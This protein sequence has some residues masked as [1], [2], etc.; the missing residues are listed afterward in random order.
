MSK[1]CPASK[2]LESLM[3]TGIEAF[4]LLSSRFNIVL[5]R[6]NIYTCLQFYY[7]FIYFLVILYT[8]V[9]FF[10]V[11][12]DTTEFC[13]TFGQILIL[14]IFPRIFRGHFV[15][16][17]WTKLDINGTIHKIERSDFNGK[18][19]IKIRLNY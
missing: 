11:L 9:I 5:Y 14:C 2:S 18:I 4:F 10:L 12:H 8:C 7:F 13:W 15:D 1:C 17:C 19:R 3:A 16:I 6:K